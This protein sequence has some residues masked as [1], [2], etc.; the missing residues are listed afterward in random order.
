MTEHIDE[1][2]LIKIAENVQNNIFNF[3]LENTQ[4]Y[5]QLLRV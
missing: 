1:G 4:G 5:K 2:I 3:S